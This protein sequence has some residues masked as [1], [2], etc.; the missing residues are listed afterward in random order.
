MTDTCLV[1]SEQSGE[2]PVPGGLLAED[3][4]AVVFHVPPRGD[5]VFLGHLLVTPRRH[6][7]DFAGLTADEAAAVGIAV[8]R[9]SGALKRLGAMRVYVATVGHAADHLHVH[10]LPRWPGTPEDVPWHSVDEWP[11]A[12]V[13][14]FA[15]AEELVSRIREN[16]R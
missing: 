13:G 2:V 8:S 5:V 3:D 16:D 10:L 7:P 1:C 14:D 9:W 15:S 11:G 6:V 4:L 12:R